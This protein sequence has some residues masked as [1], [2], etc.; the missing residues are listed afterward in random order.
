MNIN[1]L[2]TLEELRVHEANIMLK[3]PF[4]TAN[5]YVQVYKHNDTKVYKPECSNV[6]CPI[7]ID[8]TFKSW[9]EAVEF[10]NSRNEYKKL[11]SEV[12][13][14][15]N[16]WISVEERLPQE[17]DSVIVYDG[18]SIFIGYHEINYGF[19]I[20]IVDEKIEITHWMPLPEPPEVE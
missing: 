4:C 8:M 16:G 14:V 11:K 20:D 12:N 18:A 6:N 2:K 1:E 15:D 9:E 10:W 7:Y 3:C 17:F 19:Y 13:T 5:A